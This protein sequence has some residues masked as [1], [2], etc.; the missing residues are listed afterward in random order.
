MTVLDEIITGVGRTWL[1]AKPSSRSRNCWSWP[2]RRLRLGLSSPR[3]GPP[4][5]L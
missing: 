2:G 4:G 3:C 1:P 5:F